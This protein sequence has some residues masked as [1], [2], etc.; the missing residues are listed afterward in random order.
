[1]SICTCGFRGVGKD[2]FYKKM[3]SGLNLIPYDPKS[4][5]KSYKWIIYTSPDM[6]EPTFNK[7][8][9]RIGTG[10]AI[11]VETHKYLKLSK[12]DYEKVKD[13]LVVI[14]PI[15]REMKV[16]RQHYIDYADSK[17][18]NDPHHWTKIASASITKD[19]DAD[20]IKR[21]RYYN[22]DWRYFPEYEYYSNLFNSPLTIRFFRKDVPIPDRNVVSEWSLSTVTT[23]LLLVPTIDDFSEGVTLFPQYGNYIP[24]WIIHE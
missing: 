23:H 9:I 18:N 15:T 21:V 16:L 22:S 2:T 1:M 7:D 20:T 24:R 12:G 10:D 8:I 17:R 11:K 3:T 4:E 14:D 13:S 6:I 5:I 19:L